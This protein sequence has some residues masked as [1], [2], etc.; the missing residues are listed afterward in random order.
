MKKS[1]SY[2]LVIVPVIIT[3]SIYIVFYSRIVTNPS[4]AGFWMILALGMSLGVAL[5]RIIQ[6]NKEKKA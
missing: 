6:M 1:T 5:T 3:L 4:N 2:L